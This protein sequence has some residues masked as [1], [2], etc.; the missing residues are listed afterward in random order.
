MT[1]FEKI[2]GAPTAF[3]PPRAAFPAAR[4]R[5]TVVL[6]ALL[7]VYAAGFA[8]LYPLAQAQM[9]K[10]AAEGADPNALDFVGP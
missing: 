8:I 9:A 10:S 3:P 4:K 5:W 6:L 7:L 2:F 1:G